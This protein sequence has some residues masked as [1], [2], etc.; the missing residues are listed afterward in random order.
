MGDGKQIK[1]LLLLVVLTVGVCAQSR[2][3]GDAYYLALPG[4]TGDAT[5]PGH[6]HQIALT[7]FAY[8]GISGSAESIYV[9]K[10]FDSASAQLLLA[11]VTGTPITSGTFYCETA[12]SEKG[13]GRVFTMV[14]GDL[15]IDAWQSADMGASDPVPVEKVSFSFDSLSITSYPQR[16]GPG[17]P[18]VTT[19]IFAPP[20]HN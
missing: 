5:A 13:G 1:G 15:V 2:A 20:Q 16:G 8:P 17:G 10:N 3:G 12:G 14:F 11:S 4:I 19:L 6:A 9:Q 7:G 18:P